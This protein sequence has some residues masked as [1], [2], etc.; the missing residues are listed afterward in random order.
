VARGALRRRGW[1]LAFLVL[2]A[3]GPLRGSVVRTAREVTVE[4]L[5]G[6]IDARRAA[7]VS[8]RARVRLKS[9]IARVWTRQAVL[10]QRPSSV[11]I[12]VLS[13]FGLALALGTDGR[14]LWAYPPQQ[15]VRYEGPATAENLAR[16]L[17]TPLE[18]ADLVDVLLGVPP[19][20]AVFGPPGLDRDGDEHVLTLPFRGGFQEV[21]FA[22]D[23]LAVTRIEERRDGGGTLRVIFADYRDGV[24][25]AVE[26]V[27]EGGATASIA[28]DDVE[29]N[30][31]ID[32]AV[33]D[34]PPAPRTL[35]LERA[36][37]PS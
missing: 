10:L 16:L 29:R 33:F 13:P 2:A 14:T 30:A 26:L 1:L 12:D 6:E 17:G 36:G 37:A 21:R 32:P 7:I 11:R 25:R 35:P 20:R 15:G 34:P 19:A 5:L 9:G 28:F 23:T 24:A 22:A 31:T 27:A 18:V 4:E 3:C 8:L